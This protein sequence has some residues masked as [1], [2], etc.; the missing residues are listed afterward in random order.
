MTTNAAGLPVNYLQNLPVAAAMTIS[1][2]ARSVVTDNHT[3]RIIKTYLPNG[4]Q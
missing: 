3:D 1:L 2:P 4:Q